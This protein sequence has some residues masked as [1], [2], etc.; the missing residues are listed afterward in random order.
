VV[1]SVR[2]KSISNLKNLKLKINLKTNQNVSFT[3]WFDGFY[4]EGLRSRALAPPI[5]PNV[6]SV[7]DTTNFDDYPAD[8]DG[9]PP[10]DLTGFLDF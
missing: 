3:R 9:P 10:D 7:T 2:S 5:L 6:R 8:P 4:W 1:A